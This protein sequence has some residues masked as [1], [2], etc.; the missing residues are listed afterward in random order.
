MKKSDAASPPP[1]AAPAPMQ[2]SQVRQH[3]LDDHVKL[4]AQLER[5]ESLAVDT[6]DGKEGLLEL[7]R[8]ETRRFYDELLVHMKWEDE[9]L[10]RVLFEIDAWGEER[11]RR[12][13]E[14]HREQ[15]QRLASSVDALMDESRSHLQVASDLLGLIGW[16]REDMEEE[17]QVTLDPRVIRDDVI[18]VDV[19]TG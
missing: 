6:L 5:L 17:E 4:R 10:G 15:R 11:A 7:L 8:S 2:P 12:L 3:V 16:L 13:A 1:G 19:E 9:Y 14:E 18:S